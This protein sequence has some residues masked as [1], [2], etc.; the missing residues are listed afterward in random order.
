MRRRCIV[1]IRVKPWRP[2]AENLPTAAWEGFPATT[3]RPLKWNPRRAS[4][5][6]ESVRRMR[7]RGTGNG[8]K[9]ALPRPRRSGSIAA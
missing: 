3:E 7:H 1:R 6:I 4:R 2:G 8:M 9:S 5:L